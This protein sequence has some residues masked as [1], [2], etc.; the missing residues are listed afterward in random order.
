[1]ALA[2][3]VEWI[4][5][6]VRQTAAISRSSR[7]TVDRSSLE[8]ML[9]SVK[10]EILQSNC[11]LRREIKND[12]HQLKTGLHEEITEL[13]RET[14]SENL[15]MHTE[16][17]AKFGTIEGR[18]SKMQAESFAK[19]GTIEG[20]LSK[21]QAESFAKFGTIEG[22][23]SKVEDQLR[24][25]TKSLGSF[26]RTVSRVVG[27]IGYAFEV[28]NALWIKH[29]LRLRGVSGNVVTRKM[30]R[31]PDGEEYELDI[32]C[33]D[34][35]LVAEVTTFVTVIDKYERF[36]KARNAVEQIYKK[37]AEAYLL[38][39]SINANTLEDISRRADQDRVTILT[40]P[41]HNMVD[42]L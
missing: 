24:T 19:F 33:E 22:R 1:M 7:Q 41:P 3:F 4:R 21:M 14:K 6:A 17:F 29:T 23:L 32:F 5:L 9:L 15:Q 20:R 27:G 8:D 18:L 13:R 11:D 12:V 28:Y 30:I 42:E 39:Y 16:S 26:E 36:L 31:A 2:R 40:T 34:P 38:C 35:L 25:N 37:E 10:N